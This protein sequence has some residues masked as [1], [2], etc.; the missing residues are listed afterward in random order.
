M[1]IQKTLFYFGSYSQ[2]LSSND[3]SGVAVFHAAPPEGPNIFP[4]IYSSFLN[5]DTFFPSLN[6]FIELCSAYIEKFKVIY[7]FKR[8]N[9]CP[10]I[11]WCSSAEGGDS[12]KLIRCFF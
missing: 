7:S 10:F 4:L 9:K 8:R 6:L 11:L 5:T 3:H 1:Q 2:P 12:V